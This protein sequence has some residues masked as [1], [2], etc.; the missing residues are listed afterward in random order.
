M[1]ILSQ[2]QWPWYDMVF[3]DRLLRTAAQEPCEN[4]VQFCSEEGVCPVKIAE[5]KLLIPP[6]P[7]APPSDVKYLRLIRNC[8]FTPYSGLENNFGRDIV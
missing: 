1:R 4:H 2:L 7:I 6:L 3:R 8:F 5:I